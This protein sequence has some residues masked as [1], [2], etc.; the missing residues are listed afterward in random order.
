MNK[1]VNKEIKILILEDLD[2]DFELV[3]LELKRSGMVYGCRHAKSGEDFIKEL[4]NDSDVILADYNLPQFTALDALTIIKERK[5]R[6]PFILVTGTQTEEVAVECMKRGADDYILKA[7]LTRL[8]T[9]IEHALHNKEIEDEKERVQREL[10]KSENK[11]R[12]LYESMPLSVII[13]DPVTFDI[14]EVNT[15]AENLYGYSKEEFAS[16]NLADIRPSN[17]VDRLAKKKDMYFSDRA[18]YLGE[19]K[20]MN[21]AGEVFI[22]EINNYPIN[23]DG[24]ELRVSIISDIT[25]RKRTAEALQRS[26]RKYRSIFNEAPI[27]ISNIDAK[28]GIINVNKA[29]AEMMGYTHEEICRLSM[30]DLTHPSD[31]SSSKNQ[32]QDLV[33][34]KIKSMKFEKRYLKN[35]GEVL[36]AN[37]TVTA[38]NNDDGKFL[39]TISMI[40][41]I[42]ERI[43][44]ETALR[45]SEEKYRELADSLPQI[46]FETDE[47]GRLI[48]VNRQGAEFMGYERDYVESRPLVLSFVHPGDR[49]EASA[50]L[51]AILKGSET[52]GK[53]IRMI[54][55]DG[56][57]VESMIYSSPVKKENEIIGLR[58]IIV[59]VTERKQMEEDLK[60]AKE[61]A[62]EM[63]NL[64][65]VFLANMSHELRTPMIGILGYSQMIAEDVKDPEIKQMA[66]TILKSANRLTDTLNLILDLSKVEANKIDLRLHSVNINGL[67]EE[68]LNHYKLAIEEKGLKVR[69]KAAKT[70]VVC[71]VDERLFS[72]VMGNLINN[73]VKYTQEGGLDIDL[74]VEG[75][76]A[77]IKVRDTGIGI[78]ESDLGVIFEPFRQVSEGYNRRF[79]GTGLGLTISKKFV[80]L[81]NGSIIVESEVDKGSVFTVRLPYIIME[82]DAK[83]VETKESRLNNRVKKKNSRLLLVEDDRI[84]VDVINLFLRDYCSVDHS[85]SASEALEMVKTKKYDAI[86]MDINL[87]G[88]SGLEAVK[89]I[90][91]MDDY[92]NTPVIAVTAY[93]MAGDRKKILS[94]G[95]S[96]YLAKPFSKKELV[97]LLETILN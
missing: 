28:G 38:V 3:N 12:A 67:I 31:R 71:A 90:R 47:Q 95:C 42:T 66:G 57:E 85:M 34:A 18:S 63:N 94:G 68:S 72:Q 83:V 88:M 89:L 46:I 6:I 86:L 33:S 44:H 69:F 74:S 45:E 84:N 7:N 43:K 64:K 4:E 60:E 26:E 65:S 59:D 58:G 91:E 30:F 36:W 54:R 79:E 48:Y 40:E 17:E 14:K 97:E 73:A 25:D 78:K 75:K 15:A 1:K 19:W 41:D 92:K 24:K 8:P 39:Y 87:K 22:V 13:Y 56:R 37:A 29:F 49:V 9:A 82:G 76:E 80:Q 50:R 81:M 61:R 96:H 10:E 55:K 11:F 53:E 62:E 77:V 23:I 52:R 32:L 27:G 93:A 20:H 51:N 5:L 21:K 70:N 2:S 35:S 16:K